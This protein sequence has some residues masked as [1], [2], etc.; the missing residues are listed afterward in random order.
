[1]AI[2]IERMP[3]WD[4]LCSLPPW[5]L[6]LIQSGCFGRKRYGYCGVYRLFG[7]TFEGDINAPAI[8]NHLFAGRTRLAP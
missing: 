7:L 1:M 6:R 5:E 2:P 4:D 3:P 8:L